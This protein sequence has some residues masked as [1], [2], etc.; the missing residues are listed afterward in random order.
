MTAMAPWGFGIAPCALSCPGPRRG[1]ASARASKSFNT[2]RPCRPSAACSAWREKLQWLLV[3]A[4]WSPL[5]AV[6]TAI[7]AWRGAR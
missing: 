3:K 1:S 4:T 2:C 6:A 5:T 7:A